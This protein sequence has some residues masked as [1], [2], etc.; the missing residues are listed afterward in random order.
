MKSATDSLAIA[1]RADNAPAR[2]FCDDFFSGSAK[3]F[4]FG[5]NVYAE[6]IASVVRIDAF[7]DDFTTEREYLGRPVIRAEEIPADGLVVSVVVLGRPLVAEARLR[8]LG[9]RFLDYFAFAEYSRERGI[10]P[11]KFWDAFRVD[12]E[13]NRQKYDQVM[14][15]LEDV[16]SRQVLTKI[17]NFRLSGD[18]AFM[19]GFSDMQDRQ[20]FED[21]LDLKVEGESFADI[22]SFDGYTTECFIARCPDYHAIHVFEPLPDNMNMAMQRLAGY[23]RITFHGIGLSDRSQVMRFAASGSSSCATEAGTLEITA[24]RLDDVIRGPVTFAKLD[25]EG[26][27]SAALEG[28]KNI[29]SAQQPCLAVSVY[30]RFDDLWRIPEQILGYRSDY[31]LFLR[32]YTEGV[33]ETVMF[34]VPPRLD[35]R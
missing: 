28:A 21:F 2:Q 9:I 15:R 12:F 16:E 27:E 32:H 4:V 25:I 6:S 19:R 22:G 18:L 34:F 13:A 8:Q 23:S 35:D 10:L 5:R 26:A 30:H 20:Y 29:I 11:I 24:E 14:R 3:R 1:P 17:L 7:V 31:R 33:T